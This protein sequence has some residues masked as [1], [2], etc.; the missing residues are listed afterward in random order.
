MPGR[1]CL[2]RSSRHPSYRPLWVEMLTGRD[3]VD[4]ELVALFPE[5]GRG[6]ATWVRA[7]PTHLS[8]IRGM[9]YW[10]C[11][12]VRG[13]PFPNRRLDILKRQSV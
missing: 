9:H 8:M 5:V 11:T 3:V 12:Q 4:L 10:N 1:C 2:P 13:V 7:P 6:D